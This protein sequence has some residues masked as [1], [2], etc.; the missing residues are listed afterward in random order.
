M[1]KNKQQT[2]ALIVSSSLGRFQE[3]LVVGLTGFVP[4]E[5]VVL[6]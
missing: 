4:P 6:D 2:Q 5:V 1:S 3:R